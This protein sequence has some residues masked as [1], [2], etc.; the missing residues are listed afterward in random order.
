VSQQRLLFVTTQ[1]KKEEQGAPSTLMAGWSRSEAAPDARPWNVLPHEWFFGLFLVITWLRL[2][3][4]LGAANPYA[5]LFLASLTGAVAVCWWAGQEPTPL[6]WRLR[7]LYYPVIM[8]VTFYA[9]GHAI[10][11]LTETRVDTLL[12]NLDQAILGETPSVIYQAWNLPWLNDVLMLGYLFFFIHLVAVPGA[13]CVRDLA[14][15]RQ[16]IVGLF[17]IYGL[18][19]L[20]YTMLPAGG[21]HRW[22]TF[23]TPLTGWFVIPATLAAVNEGSNGADVFPSLHLA[24]SFYLLVFDWWHERRRFW[25]CLMPC[26]ILW[27]S[28]VLLRFHYF[29]DLLG[30]LALALLSLFIAARYEQARQRNESTARE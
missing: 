8:G 3:W 1:T 17:T 6:R 14:R 18:G 21:P 7:L 4:H 24:V 5:L 29:V 20:S 25:V 15:F 16:C 11:A 27:C 28:T 9:L 26:V 13:Y 30:G 10:P 12:L 2:A 23:E 19:F 22:M